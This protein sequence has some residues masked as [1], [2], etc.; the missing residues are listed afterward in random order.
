V[1]ALVNSPWELGF[2]LSCSSSD[3]FLCVT[4]DLAELS[5]ANRHSF[6]DIFAVGSGRCRLRCTN[7]VTIPV[8]AMDTGYGLTA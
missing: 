2:G 6:G 4:R 7:I 1:E 8:T 5:F 3:P